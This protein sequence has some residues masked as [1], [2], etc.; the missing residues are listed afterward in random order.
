MAIAN[1]EELELAIR[2]EVVL[3][4]RATAISSRLRNEDRNPAFRAVNLERAVPVH[5]QS[6]FRPPS[7]VLR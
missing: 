1:F 3:K 5:Y 2:F 4:F 7:Y 6:A